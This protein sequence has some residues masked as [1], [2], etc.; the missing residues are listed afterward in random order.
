MSI[1]H[2]TILSPVPDYVTKDELWAAV[3]YGTQYMVLNNGKQN[4]VFATLPEARAF[5]AKKIKASTGGSIPK[6]PKKSKN[7]SKGTLT[8]FLQ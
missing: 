4:E 2:T 6:K 7:P 3:P 1:L 5:I 8:P